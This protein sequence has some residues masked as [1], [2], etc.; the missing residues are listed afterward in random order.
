MTSE[1]YQCVCHTCEESRVKDELARA[2]EYFNNHADDGCEV[3]LR[4]VASTV[5]PST[6]EA[7]RLEATIA[8]SQST[9]E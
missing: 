5:N 1:R 6:T 4:N 9:D 7:T 2:Q 3:V 8:D